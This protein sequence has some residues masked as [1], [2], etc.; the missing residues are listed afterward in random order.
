L[1]VGGTRAKEPVGRQEQT[2]AVAAIKM[3]DFMVAF[4]VCILFF[5]GQEF[6]RSYIQRKKKVTS[7][8]FKMAK[9]TI[10]LLCGMKWTPN[11]NSPSDVDTHIVDFFSIVI[12]V[13]QLPPLG[14]PPTRTVV[15][16]YQ[17]ERDVGL[18]RRSSS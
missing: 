17:Y 13:D 16:R 2:T 14:E 6:V 1:L 7:A 11:N 4:G 10:I 9:N 12:S 8:G 15:L 18:G 3:I 5:L